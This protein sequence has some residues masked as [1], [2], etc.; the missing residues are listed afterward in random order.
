MHPKD[1]LLL[2][3]EG[4]LQSWGV[5]SK[6]N[7]RSSLDFPT[8]SGVMGLLLSAMGERGDQEE[9][10][11]HF[12]PLPQTVIAYTR[13]NR[14]Q[15]VQLRDFHMVGSGYDNKD[16]WQSQHIPKTSEGK[17]AKVVSGAKLTHRYYVQDGA[18]AV[19]MPIPSDIA[20]RLAEALQMP[21]WDS[22]LGR[23]SCVPTEFIFQ[24]LH[25][26]VDAA[27]QHAAQLA[28]SK[29]REEVFRVRELTDSKEREDVFRMQDGPHDGDEMILSDIP[30]CFGK[31]KRYTERRVIVVSPEAEQA[32]RKR[33]NSKA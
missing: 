7:V 6:F 28:D 22:C 14:Q 13:R 23:R 21:C 27:E 3:L 30:L 31:I 5:N 33:N 15:P 2:W 26:T 24:G 17:N 8:R 16:P 20:P 11:S 10:L 19:I 32:T 25:E 18:F 12:A 9:L 1:I 29:E 4:P